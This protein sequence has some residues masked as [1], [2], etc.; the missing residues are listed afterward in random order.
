MARRKSV[1]QREP[2][3]LR[4]I[5]DIYW[6][7]AQ[8][9]KARHILIKQTWSMDFL[10]HTLATAARLSNDYTMQLVIT[11]K[12]GMSVT[13]T[14][15]DTKR[16]QQEANMTSILDQLDNEAAVDAFVRANARR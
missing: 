7:K 12:D 13:L 9:V 5:V 4:K 8:A 16:V 6:H 14:C 3:L 1:K 15:A 11:N 10:A 2:S